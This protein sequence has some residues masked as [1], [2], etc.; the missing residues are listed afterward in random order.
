MH[1]GVI[2]LDQTIGGDRRRRFIF[3]VNFSIFFLFGGDFDFRGIFLTFE[4]L[5]YL[6]FGWSAAIA[7]TFRQ[8]TDITP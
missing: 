7:H 8:K 6:L 2:G 1:N 5:T 4:V 3:V